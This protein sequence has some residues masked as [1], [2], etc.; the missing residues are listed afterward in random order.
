[1]FASN[2]LLFACGQ[3]RER[4]ESAC[5]F[6]SF[7]GVKALSV[8]QKWRWWGLFFF[9]LK[10]CDAIFYTKPQQHF[11]V[12]NIHSQN[13]WQNIQTYIKNF[14][15]WQLH[16]SRAFPAFICSTFLRALLHNQSK[17]CLLSLTFYADDALSFFCVWLKAATAH[18]RALCYSMSL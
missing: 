17:N 2:L 16:Y 1:M 4:P 15:K 10:R 13:N 14:P 7:T 11:S 12:M 9:F 3:R 6:D 5:V 18:S 8:L